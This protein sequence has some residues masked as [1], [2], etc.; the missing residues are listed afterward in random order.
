MASDEKDTVVDRWLRSIK[1]QKLLA[2]VIVLGI[3]V[4]AVA[5]F[6]ES[7]SKI[8]K[9]WRESKEQSAVP[10]FTHVKPDYTRH[11]RLWYP[12]LLYPEL[13]TKIE[14]L[15][16]LAAADGINLHYFETYR[17]PE[18][19]H[20]MYSATPRATY[21][22]AWSS[23]KQYGMAA[24]LGLYDGTGWVYQPPAELAEK[25]ALLATTVGLRQEG[26]VGIYVPWTYVLPSVNVSDLKGGTYPPRIGGDDSWADNLNA[27]ISTWVQ[28]SPSAPPLVKPRK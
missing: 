16:K 12:S 15:R 23:P 17:P 21:A 10:S 14:A 13:R 7:L 1:N 25:V 22:D 3:S 5:S 20:E 4:G 19:Q 28:T 8:S 6:T 9:F 27:Q 11:T 26:K 24:T 18:I 2:I